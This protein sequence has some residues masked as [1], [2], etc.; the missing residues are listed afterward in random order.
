MGKGKYTYPQGHG[1][2]QKDPTC[3]FFPGFQ[4]THFALFLSIDLDT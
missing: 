3:L 1:Q 4:E 2:I